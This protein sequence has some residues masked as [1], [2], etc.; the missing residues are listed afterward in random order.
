MYDLYE[1]PRIGKSTEVESRLVVAKGWEED[2][3]EWRQKLEPFL[4][5]YTKIIIDLTA[6]TLKIWSKSS[7]PWIKQ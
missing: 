6:K 4:T 1:I 2:T 7:Q 3:K 5:P